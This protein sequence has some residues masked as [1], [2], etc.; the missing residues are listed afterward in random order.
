MW[1]CNYIA[2]LYGVDASLRFNR[3]PVEWNKSGGAELAS[4]GSVYR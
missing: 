4:R 3:C 2:L 1:P